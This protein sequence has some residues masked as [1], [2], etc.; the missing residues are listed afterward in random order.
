[1]AVQAAGLARCAQPPPPAQSIGSAK[2]KLSR[3][4][5]YFDNAARSQKRRERTCARARRL[6]ASSAN[7]AM[8]IT[9]AWR[10]SLA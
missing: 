8:A 4:Q 2:L 3:S 1:M 9:S 5:K 10:A 6:M 7:R